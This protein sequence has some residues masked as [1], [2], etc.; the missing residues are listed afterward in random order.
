MASSSKW[1]RMADFRSDGYG[2]EPRRG[3]QP[4][5]MKIG[6]MHDSI[7]DIAPCESCVNCNHKL[8][9]LG[10]EVKPCVWMLSI[11]LTKKGI[12]SIDELRSLFLR[13]FK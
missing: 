12:M 8:Q 11:E 1:T 3:Y 6:E 4:F 7:I 9:C 13:R 2:F 5:I 10:S